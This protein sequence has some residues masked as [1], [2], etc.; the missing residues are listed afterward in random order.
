MNITA[1]AIPATVA[2]ARPSSRPDLDP[3]VGRQLWEA[4]FA[5]LNATQHLADAHTQAA[6][7]YAAEGYDDIAQI[8]YAYAAAVAN[9][10]TGDDAWDWA[11]EQAANYDNGLVEL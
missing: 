5:A 2:D 4:E 9:G 8:H 6:N 3:V 7:D 10:M 1:P 11:A